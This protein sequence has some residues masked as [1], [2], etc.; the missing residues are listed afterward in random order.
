MASPPSTGGLSG[1]TRADT[2]FGELDTAY[3]GAKHKDSRTSLQSTLPPSLYARSEAGL[4]SVKSRYEDFEPHHN[5]QSARSVKHG[6]FG[7][8]VSVTIF[9]FALFSTA[10]S[11][12]FLILALLG[13]TFRGIRSEGGPLTPGTAAFITSLFARLIELSF[14]SVVIAFI[15][16]ALA[17]RAFKLEN[18]R[19]VTLAEMSMRTWVMQPGTVFTQWE[20]VK[21]AGVTL[22]GAISLLAALLALLYTSAATALVQ[23]QLKFPDWTHQEMQ[24]IVSMSFANSEAVK[25]GCSNPNVLN[26]GDGPAATEDELLTCLQ[27]EHAAMSYHNYHS[28]LEIWTEELGKGNGS[29]LLAKRPPGYAL[30]TDNTTIVA[31]WIERNDV[32][33]VNET[34]YVNN[35]TMAMPHVGVIQAAQDP[36]N[37][38]V[39]PAEVEGATYNIRAAVPSPK[40]NV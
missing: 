6:R 23:P 36:I 7:N 32:T 30:Y 26:Y 37:R 24:G 10:F 33:T 12:I 4:L 1:S 9:I 17:R 19:G 14:V 5:C 31:P 27:I 39:Q 29:S 28:W 38:I 20:S 18:R 13:P 16:Q 40:I 34:R 8:C 21:Y 3:R 25:H 22:L 11:L 15:G 2:S 35:V